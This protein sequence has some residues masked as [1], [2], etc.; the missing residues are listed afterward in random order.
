[1]HQLL[2]LSELAE[3]LK[4]SAETIK[5]DLRRSPEA[6]PPRVLIP[7]TRAL[8]W[9]VAD[10]EEWIANLVTTETKEATGADDE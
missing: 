2:N 5:K 4:R 7:G 3:I 10:V 9:R 6:V 8:R 1:M